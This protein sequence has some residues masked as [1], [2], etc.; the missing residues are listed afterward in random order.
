[1]KNGL[2]YVH[3]KSPDDPQ[4]TVTSVA[5]DINYTNKT[6]DVQVARCRYPDN[7]SRKVSHSICEGR[8]KKYGP[9]KTYLMDEEF[10]MPDFLTQLEADWVHH[11]GE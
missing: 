7:W 11:G 1:M 9:S 4:H 10:K 3:F 2:K 8:L 5:M 6:I